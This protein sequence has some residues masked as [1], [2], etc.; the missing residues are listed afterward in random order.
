MPK[1]LPN[2]ASEG[3]IA[4]TVSYN[5]NSNSYLRRTARAM[6]WCSSGVW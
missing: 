1:P 3:V 4:I 2:N 6:R 5:N